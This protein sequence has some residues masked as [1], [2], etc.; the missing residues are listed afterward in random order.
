MKTHWFPLILGRLK[1]KPLFLVDL[2]WQP[3]NRVR[4]IEELERQQRELMREVQSIEP[5]PKFDF[6]GI[7]TNFFFGGRK[8]SL[9]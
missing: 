3:G 4:R 6:W 8:K 1:K 9:T 7:R 5:G 2:P